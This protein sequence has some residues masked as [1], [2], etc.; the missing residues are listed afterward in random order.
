ML[1]VASIPAAVA[2]YHG[3]LGLKVTMQTDDL[4]FFDAGSV[5][6]AVSSEVGRKVGDDEVVFAVE[7]VQ[8]AFDGLSQA[9][10]VFERKPHALTDTAWAASFRD[11]DG[12][13]LSVYGP[14]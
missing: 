10:I 2:F 5:S 6:I 13:V 4:V 7:H 14:R 12:H 3:K 8:A 1:G 11:P 9:G